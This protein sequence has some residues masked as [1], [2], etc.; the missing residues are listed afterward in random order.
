MVREV[1]PPTAHQLKSQISVREFLY[2]G[3]FIFQLCICVC[4]CVCV[5]ECVHILSWGIKPI[6]EM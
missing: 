1:D 2:P 3:T 6:L 5:S 4:V